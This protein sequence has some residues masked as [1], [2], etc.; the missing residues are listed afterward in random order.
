MLLPVLWFDGLN[1]N[2]ESWYSLRKQTVMISRRRANSTQIKNSWA[3]LSIQI[4]ANVDVMWFQVM[5]KGIDDVRRL[6]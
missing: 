4:K 1:G 5:R 2:Y 3:L 6:V